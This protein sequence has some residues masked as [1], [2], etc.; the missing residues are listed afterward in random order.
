MFVELLGGFA[1]DVAA[2]DDDEDVL[3]AMTVSRRR[4]R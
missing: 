2:A 4:C 3:G 1:V